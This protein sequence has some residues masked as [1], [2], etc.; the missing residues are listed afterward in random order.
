MEEYNFLYCQKLVVLSQDKSKVLLC[1]RKGEADYDGTF[2]FIGGKMEHKDLDILT[3]LKREKD[4][5][6]GENF[7]I[8][9]YTKFT[10]NLFFIRKDGRRMILPHYLAIHKEED[11]DLNEEYSE[12]KWVDIDKLEEFEP[13]IASIPN[14]VKVLLELNS[15]IK[16][17]DLITI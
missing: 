4:E 3:G 17:E 10:N 12:Y 11:I 16:D 7:K 13:K 8:K 15:I 14:C 6:V 1:K 2:A 9:T 5:E